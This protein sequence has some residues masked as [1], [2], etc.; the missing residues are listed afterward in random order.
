MRALILRLLFVCTLAFGLGCNG[1]AGGGG[2]SGMSGDKSAGDPAQSSGQVEGQEQG[3]STGQG[4]GSDSTQAEGVP[5]DLCL[6]VVCS[7]DDWCNPV[8]GECMSYT[9][10]EA[11]PEECLGLGDPT[12]GVHQEFF[13]LLNE[14]RV[15]SGAD[16][17]EYSVT[18]EAAADAFAEQMWTED[19]FSH[20][21][22]DGTTKGDRV[23]A[24]GFCHDGVGENIA[25]GKNSRSTPGAAMEALLDSTDHRNNMLTQSYRYVGVGFFT[26]TDEEG[27]WFWWV[28]VF[29]NDRSN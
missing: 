25:R 23:L 12:P 28:Q 29:A 3:Q 24:A 27:Q 2:G 1:P 11:G 15:V 6:N 20:T 17:L 14:F 4:S 9:P 13:E 22:P 8:T 7:G 19:F 26:T 5:A 10:P 18:L 21:A 16:A